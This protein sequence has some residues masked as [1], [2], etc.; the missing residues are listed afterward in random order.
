MTAI[1]L[2]GFALVLAALVGIA[3]AHDDDLPF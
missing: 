1:I 3:F 2:F